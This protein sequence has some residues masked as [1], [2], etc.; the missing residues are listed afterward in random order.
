MFIIE[1]YLVGD[2]SK[3]QNV[4]SENENFKKKLVFN[5]RAKNIGLY[6]QTLIILQI[7]DSVTKLTYQISN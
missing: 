2:S 4:K 5:Y 7:S 6:K 3:L 1:N